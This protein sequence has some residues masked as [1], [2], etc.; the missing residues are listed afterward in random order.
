MCSSLSP[1]EQLQSSKRNRRRLRSL[2]E[3]RSVEQT[4]LLWWSIVGTGCVLLIVLMAV[5]LAQPSR[6][7]NKERALAVVNEK[8]I[9][10][11]EVDQAIVSQLLPLEQQI[12]VLR[13]A[14]LENLIARTILESEASRLRI[15]VEELRQRLTTGPVAVSDKEVEELYQENATVFASMSPD[16]AR[17][18]LRLDLE[19]Q[20]RMRLYREGLVKL[21]AAAKIELFLDEPRLRFLKE[22]AHAPSRGPQNAAVSIAEFSDFQCPYCKAAQPTIEQIL[23]LYPKDVRLVFRHLPSESHPQSMLLAIASFCADEQNSFWKYH[24]N[25]FATD[26]LS[27]LTTQSAEEFARRLG[28]DSIRFRKCLSSEAARQT[29]QQDVR[30][31]RRLGINSTPTFVINGRL[32]RGVS[33]FETFRKIIQQELHPENSSNSAKSG[34]SQ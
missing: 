18:K 28:L 7:Q 34:S 21:K 32:L 13:K 1:Y 25:L 5:V 20:G 33:S 11:D 22:N 30:E 6:G 23:R 19:A 12:Y 9:W 15:S 2:V 3:G 14:A 26:D 16:E 27:A 24:D 29:V 31:A 4:P 17:E 8:T 10:S